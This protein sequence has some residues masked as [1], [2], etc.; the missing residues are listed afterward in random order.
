M[1]R[2]AFVKSLILGSCTALLPSET[3]AAAST[4]IAR[5]TRADD[6]VLAAVATA[7]NYLTGAINYTSPG[8]Q[9]A[10]KLKYGRDDWARDGQ[11]SHEAQLLAS[12]AGFKVE[13]GKLGDWGSVAALKYLAW[14]KRYPV[15]FLDGYPQHA[16]VALALDGDSVSYADPQDGQIYRLQA[17]QLYRLL[18]NEKWY[19]T[20]SL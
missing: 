2:L 11:T 12:D 15:I 20:A 17:E 10:Y 4:L 6:C 7:L 18:E 14:A 8:L 9:L 16:I 1:N 3:E 13:F 19:F 5:Q